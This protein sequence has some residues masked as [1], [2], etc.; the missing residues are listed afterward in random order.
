M[1]E[2][3]SI[4]ALLRLAGPMV[5]A[6][7]SQSVVTFADAY[8]VRHLGHEAIAAVATGGLN[9]MGFLM[10]AW[11]LVFIIQ[12]FVAQLA[13]RGARDE[14]PRFAWYGL[15]LA[16]LAGA[17]AAAMIPLIGP[18][19]THTEYSPGVRDH[20]ASYMAIRLLSVG[21]VIGVEALGNWYGGLGN[22]WVQMAAGL[23]TMV[24]AVFFNWVL[25]D[26]HLGAP[27]MGVDGAALASTI[28]SGLGFAFAFAVF[29]RR[30]GGAPTTPA[31]KLSLRELGRVVR[32]GLPNG[33]NWFLELAA[34]QLFV[35][36]M[37]A[38][39]GGVTVAALNVVL[40]VNSLSFMPAFG[41]ASAGAILAGQAIGAGERDRVWPQVK[42]TLACNMVWMGTIA[43]V[44]LVFPRA[45]LQLFDSEHG[46]QLVVI[47][48]SM[49]AISAAWQLADAVGMTLSETLRAAGDTAWTAMVRLAVAW[50][51]FLPAAYLVV[52]RRHGGPNGAM[53][54][55]VGYIALQSG[56]LAWRFRSGRWKQIQL[57][58]PKLV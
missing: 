45:V 19:L 28:A 25:I 36:G 5:L 38:G 12:S 21:A 11:G 2:P 56:L 48:A 51:G 39:L 27:A 1:S 32:F 23:L 17:I 54:C 34:F 16:G 26:G 14:A 33:L 41:L 6:R 18:I 49:L 35:N 58:E 46:G 3:A 40:A 8:Q 43:V 22:T 24:T 15:I 4:K 13:G 29:W 57:I 55:L 47:G 31:G 30:A 37:L 42:I 50:F 52:S 20:M 53:L 44:Y 10:L 9:V 7:A